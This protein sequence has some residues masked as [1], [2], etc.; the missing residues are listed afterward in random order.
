MRERV[1]ITGASKGI[2]AA[3]AR[4]LAEKDYQVIGTALPGENLD[5]APEGVTFLRLNLND[6]HS[7]ETCLAEAGEIDILINCAGV[8]Q[9]GPLEEYPIEKMRAL[10][11]TNVFGAVQMTQALLPRM[12]RMGKGFIINIGS[13]AG[14]FAVPFQ[15]GYVASKYAVAGW[16]WALR[17]EVK[18]FGVRVVVIEPNDIRTTITPELNL[19]PGSDYCDDV[20]C[21]K[22]ARAESMK[23]ACGPEGVARKVLSILRSKKPRPFY[24]VGGA[25]PFMVFLK[26]FV[27]D[28]LLEKLIRRNYGLK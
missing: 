8:S 7:I 11:Q 19:H 27:P 20:E 26:R 18:K 12:R 24:T 3:T 15:T 5:D 4:L 10:F 22:K 14:K 28:T 13:L 9:V 21:M 2:G 17:S 1:L 16:S 6:D 25:G 23:K